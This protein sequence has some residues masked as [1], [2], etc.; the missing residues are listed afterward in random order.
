VLKS[1]IKKIKKRNVIGHDGPDHFVTPVLAL[2]VKPTKATQERS[3]RLLQ[4]RL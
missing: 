3:L 4:S 1:H 2:E